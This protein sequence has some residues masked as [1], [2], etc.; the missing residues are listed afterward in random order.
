MKE[1]RIKTQRKA[2][3]LLALSTLLLSIPFGF[4]A[5]AET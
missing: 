5:L 3:L 2:A 4:H 1:K